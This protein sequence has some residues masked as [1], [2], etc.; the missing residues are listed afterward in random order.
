MSGYVGLARILTKVCRHILRYAGLP[1]LMY[2]AGTGMPGYLTYRV[3]GPAYTVQ[4][5]QSGIYGPG[6]GQRSYPG[7][8]S[9]LECHVPTIKGENI[10]AWRQSMV[11]G[12]TVV[13]YLPSLCTSTSLPQRGKATVLEVQGTGIWRPIESNQGQGQG[14]L[15]SSSAP[16]WSVVRVS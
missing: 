11:T 14:S 15:P 4:G 16:I 3:G 10:Q 7:Y 8:I 6:Y 13:V 9:Q 5:W 2:C 12:C 1:Y